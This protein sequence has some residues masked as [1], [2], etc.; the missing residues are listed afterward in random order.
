MCKKIKNKGLV[1]L[2][3]LGLYIIA[4]VFITPNPVVKPHWYWNLDSALYYIV[5]YCIGWV[6]FERLNNFF[7]SSKKI[8]IW[9]VIIG[10]FAYS[11]NLFLGRNILSRI[12][13]KNR[14]FLEFGNIMTPMITIMM[15]LGISYIFSNN[16]LMRNIG[17]SSL[18]LC[19][20]EYIVKSLLPVVLSTFGITINLISPMNV[21]IYTLVL[22]VVVYKIVIPIERM[23]L[24]A[25]HSAN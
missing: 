24:K 22:I 12:Y 7:L 4:D 16:S 18:C 3:C 1:L 21:C 17:K 9:L 19:G 13:E 20:N 5:F 14:L 10:T 25:I 8:V 15:I 11:A 2:V 6:V 23:L